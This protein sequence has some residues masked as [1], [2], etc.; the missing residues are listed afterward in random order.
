M[1]NLSFSWR[2]IVFYEKSQTM[3]LVSKQ[4]SNHAT[5]LSLV[6]FY[7]RPS[8]HSPVLAAPCP[9]LVRFKKNTLTNPL[10]YAMLQI[11]R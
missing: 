6:R 5:F 8:L 2:D 4:E 9:A 11:E 1:L 7:D 10:S 3:T